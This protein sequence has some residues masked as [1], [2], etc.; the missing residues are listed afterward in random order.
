MSTKLALNITERVNIRGGGKDAAF[1][2][3]VQTRFSK[4]AL[5]TKHL[6]G[7]ERDKF[8]AELVKRRDTLNDLEKSLERFKER[9]IKQANSP[10]AIS[11]SK[12]GNRRVRV[13]ERLLGKM[14][15]EEIAKKYDIGLEIVGHIAARV[16]LAKEYERLSDRVRRARKRYIE[17]QN[18]SIELNFRFILKNAAR[19][20][21]SVPPDKFDDLIQECVF[22]WVRGLGTYDPKK[23]Q[24]TTHASFW[25]YQAVQ[26]DVFNDTLIRIPCYMFEEIGRLDRLGIEVPEDASDY[27]KE[28]IHSARRLSRKKSY[29]SLDRAVQ[30]EEDSATFADFLIDD[31]PVYPED[32][33]NTAEMGDMVKSVLDF[34]ESDRE[35][36][37]LIRRFG[38][39]G[40][41]DRETLDSIAEDYGLTR[42]RVRQIESRALEKIRINI[43]NGRLKIRAS[44]S[45]RLRVIQGGGE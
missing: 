17:Y 11:V 21:V 25:I 14:P 43:N 30:D 20:S 45:V 26:R 33:V 7:K 12:L 35:R 24:L 44:K 19:Y 28:G 4:E 27:M 34:L 38:L 42:E 2:N 18:K 36:D 8:I 1:W 5:R 3:H 9:Q 39:N 6:V 31:N 13:I 41:D 22:G 37:I 15:H 32:L 23:G 29:V 16:A 10:I 40:K